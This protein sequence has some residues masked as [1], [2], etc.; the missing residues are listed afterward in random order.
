[1][2]FSVRTVLRLEIPLESGVIEV[3]GGGGGAGAFSLREIDAF[4]HASKC[5]KDC[6]GSCI[7][8]V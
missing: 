3:T 1:M 5:S 7:Q 8:Q 6:F 2:L 4:N